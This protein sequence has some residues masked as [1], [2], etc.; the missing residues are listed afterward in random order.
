MKIDLKN[1]NLLVLRRS[2]LAANPMLVESG[3]VVKFGEGTFTWNLRDTINYELDRGRLEDVRRGDETPIDIS[4]TGK[5]EYIQ[6]YGADVTNHLS[7]FEALDGTLLNGDP[8]PW[9]AAV[10]GAPGP[11]TEA[12]LDCAPY[13]VALELHNDLRRECPAVI[14]PPPIYPLP[15]EAILFRYFRVESHAMDIKAGTIA[16]T[17]KCN[18]TD[19]LV[20]RVDDFPYTVDELPTPLDNWPADPRA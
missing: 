17:G 11:E 2:N 10:G 14:G 19:P 6:A 16:V 7:L 15:L 3:M 9:I 20:Q 12:W 18:I 4:L 1:V 5:Y 13:C 8:S